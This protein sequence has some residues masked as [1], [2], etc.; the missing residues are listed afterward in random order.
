MKIVKW[1]LLERIFK[2]GS[3]LILLVLILPSIASAIDD[4]TVQAIDSKASEAKSKAEGNNSRIQAPEAEDIILHERI[5]NIQLTPG[6]K[7]DKG[8]PGPIGPQGPVGETGPAG[9][10]GE[11]G[12]AGP[13]G[14]PGPQGPPGTPGVL[15][16]AGK[17][18]PS[19]LAVVGFDESGELIC[20]APW[21]MPP[22]GQPPVLSFNCQVNYDQSVVETQ[23]LSAV[24]RAVDVFV[25]GIPDIDNGTS[26]LS[27]NPAEVSGSANITG[28]LSELTEA[29]PCSDAILV[30]A[31]LPDI[32]ITGD[33]SFTR[34]GFT[35]TG[36]FQIDVTG[37]SIELITQLSSP[38]L[39]SA[40][41]G[42]TFD[43]EVN[44]TSVTA[45]NGSAINLD[46]TGGGIIG[47]IIDLISNSVESYFID[48][49]LETLSTELTSELSGLPAPVTVEVVA[50]P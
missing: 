45:Y 32:V 38:D 6:P 16:L 29:E 33:W 34:L 19:S 30:T 24:Q 3:S 23:L 44:S 7:G 48:A 46:L 50:A 49:V 47:P 12:P 41:P 31:M 10:Q 11:P 26:T 25:V 8:D 13:Q 5:D 39:S 9:P 22:D 37:L 2:L 18:C 42:D 21:N 4:A 20:A 27:F 17:R 40:S 35:Y 14:E 28:V 43:R 36:Q 1:K 15:G